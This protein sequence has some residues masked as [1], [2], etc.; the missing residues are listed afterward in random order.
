[1]SPW[2][3]LA[4]FTFYPDQKILKTS[5]ELV[6]AGA[7][8]RLCVTQRSGRDTVVT[9]STITADIHIL[10]KDFG[11]TLKEFKVLHADLV[12]VNWNTPTDAHNCSRLCT[13]CLLRQAPFHLHICVLLIITINMWSFSN[14]MLSSVNKAHAYGAVIWSSK[15]N[16]QYMQMRPLQRI[17]V[18]F[19]YFN[20][21]TPFLCLFA[22]FTS[23]RVQ[24]LS[25]SLTHVQMMIIQFPQKE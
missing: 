11:Y 14:L 7:G 17:S 4:S 18:Q 3:P 13:V 19:I 12:L 24:I 6:S 15:I 5:S 21:G 10:H 9:L 1:M 2:C 23:A 25:I 20:P 22:W 16:S 8:L